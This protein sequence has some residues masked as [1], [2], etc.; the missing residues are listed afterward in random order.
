MSKPVPDTL[1]KRNPHERDQNIV[2]DEGP[3]IYTVFG[4]LGYTSVTTWVHHLF[5]DFDAEA[6]VNNIMKSKKMIDDPTY[7]YY[8]KTKQEI[9]DGWNKNRD[10]SASK[11]TQMHYDIECYYNDWDVTNDSPEYSYFI[12]FRTDYPNLKPYRTEW[13]VYYDELKLS[14]SIDMVFQDENDGKF[15]I[16]DWKRCKEIPHEG[17]NGKCAKESCIQHLPDSKF[18][19]Y[20]L[21]LNTYRRFLEDKYNIPIEGMYL[22]CMHPDNAYKTYER[23]QVQRLEKE[24]NDLFDIRR[25]EAKQ[26]VLTDA[27]PTNT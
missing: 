23:I 24:M 17:F 25:E 7:K 3:H 2:F 9:L 5:S 26:V 27:P 12:Q 20:S 18:W 21:Q 11:G 22:V 4:K 13:V 16:Y 6:V 14:G 10:D 19:H 15:Y 8:G 1:A